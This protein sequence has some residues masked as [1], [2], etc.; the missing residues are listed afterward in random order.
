MS[1]ENGQARLQAELSQKQDSKAA[2]RLRMLFDNG[3]YTELDRFA[4]NGDAPCEAIAAV[5]LVN[6]D[7]VY[8]FAQDQSVACGAM[9]RAQS[10]KIKRVFDLAAQNGAPVVGIYDSNGAHIDEGVDA[11]A[12]YGDLILASGR[13]SGVVPQISVVLG[14]CVGSSAVLAG[15]ADLVIMEKDAEFCLHGS[16][17]TGAS[18]GTAEQAL[19]NGTCAVVAEGEL[20]AVESAVQAL[21]YMPANNLGALQLAQPVAPQAM[22]CG[23]ALAGLLDTDSLLE[24]SKTFGKEAV[25]GFARINGIPVGVVSTNGDRLNKNAVAKIARFVRLCDAFSIPLVTLLD[26]AGFMGDD[27]AE[28]S[29]DVRAVS[30]LTHAYAEATTAKISVVTGKAYGLAYT[31]F[32]GRGANA[33]M[34]FA[35]PQAVISALD[36]VTAV[37]FLHKD[38][39]DGTNRKDLE[40]EYATTEGSPFVA[41]AKGYIDD[42]I[43]PA[44]TAQ[45]VCN[46]LELLASKRVSTLNKK[47]SNIPL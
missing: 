36:P 8:A 24:L 31:A 12:A 1:C 26:C 4:K 27:T 46:A 21:S 22:Q 11:L 40:Q 2:Q 3:C 33:D 7:Q 47:H 42:I 16:A 34:V 17:I 19:A 43:D 15:L 45:R 28:L 41:A 38:K 39:L 23:N 13:I 9:G 30:M 37:Q 5:G 35:W 32:A 10:L 29:G 20:A 25:V 6:G 14:P 18:T 44:D